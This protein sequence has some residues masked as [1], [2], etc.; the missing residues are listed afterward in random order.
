M[1]FSEIYEP[2][3]RWSREKI[4]QGGTSFNES[5]LPGLVIVQ[6]WRI[7]VEQREMKKEQ[8]YTYRCHYDELKR[9]VISLGIKDIA[10]T[11]FN[12]YATLVLENSRY[13][14]KDGLG[15]FGISPIVGEFWLLSMGTSVPELIKI[16]SSARDTARIL[17][18]FDSMIPQIRRFAES[19]KVQLQ[20]EQTAREITAIAGIPSGASISPAPKGELFDIEVSLYNHGRQ[21]RFLCST[22]EEAQNLLRGFKP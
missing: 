14:M 4:I 20:A 7:V 22:I 13:C 3:A 17:L 8:R 9:E 19:L 15:G 11:K 1:E 6:A 2:L 18:G 12:D 16:T 21:E 5:D 10:F